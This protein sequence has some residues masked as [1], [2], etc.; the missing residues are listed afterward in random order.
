MRVLASLL[1]IFKLCF[2]QIVSYILFFYFRIQDSSLSI[3][4]CS[5]ENYTNSRKLNESCNLNFSIFNA[6]SPMQFSHILF[7]SQFVQ[8][9]SDFI[10]TMNLR[11]RCI[12]NAFFRDSRCFDNPNSK[13]ARDER[14]E[15]GRKQ[16]GKGMKR[17]G[18]LHTT[19]DHYLLSPFLIFFFFLFRQEV[20]EECA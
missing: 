7:S 11:P 17:E 1:I 8:S 9:L 4:C 14:M 12:S 2:L 10:C 16:G 20:E 15:R 5:A 13:Q 6:R 3:V 19:K 18:D